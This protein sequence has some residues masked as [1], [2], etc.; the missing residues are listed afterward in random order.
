MK[1]RKIAQNTCLLL[2]LGGFWT[3]SLSAVGQNGAQAKAKLPDMRR[4]AFLKPYGHPH[5]SNFSL[6][7]GGGTGAYSGDICRLTDRHL[8]NNYLNP[9]VSVGALYRITDFV[10]MRWDNQWQRLRAEARPGTW[11]GWNFRTDVLASSVALQINV[12]SKTK[13]EQ[14]RRGWDA[15]FFAGGGILFH[16]TNTAV[17]MAAYERFSQL[18]VPPVHNRSAVLPLGIGVSWHKSDQTAVGLE[19][20]YTL[21]TTDGLD[22]ASLGIDPKPRKDDFL[23][24]QFRVTHQLFQLF[25][26][27]SY[28][29]RK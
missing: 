8:Q 3:T 16:R 29:K 18:L 15:Y 27:T 12:S 22:G 11:G 1:C 26:Y 25:R 13:L 23:M 17:D 21:T 19:A 5:Q 10:S 24:L 14:A 6:T 7:A 9:G 20:A 2:V 28:L 4:N